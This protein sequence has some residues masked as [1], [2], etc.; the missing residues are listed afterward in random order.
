MN[1]KR[2]VTIA[3]IGVLGLACWLAASR[4]TATGFAAPT[5]CLE[6]YR[7]ACQNGDVSQYFACLGEPLRS[8]MRKRNAMDEQ[9]AA[10]LRT[11]MKTVNS[12]VELPDSVQT[13][14][15]ARIRVETEGPRG[16]RRT[17][18]DLEK[19]RAGWLIVTIGPPQEVSAP[20]RFGTHVGDSPK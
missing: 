2:L 13:G 10:A 5:D 1:R 14:S 8:Q 18:F 17:S 19:T 7:D 11:E 6:A 20:I 3:A 16:I 15:T 12:W 4:P 9:L